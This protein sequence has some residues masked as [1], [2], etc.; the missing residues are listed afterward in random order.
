MMTDLYAR[1]TIKSRKKPNYA[2][3]F[4][5]PFQIEPD[6]TVNQSIVLFGKVGA[7][8]GFMAMKN[9]NRQGKPCAVCRSYLRSLVSRIMTKTIYIDAPK[10]KEKTHICKNIFLD[11]LSLCQTVPR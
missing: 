6:G 11:S 5:D 4:F 3:I 10:I 8:F 9:K 7:K 1:T 2:K